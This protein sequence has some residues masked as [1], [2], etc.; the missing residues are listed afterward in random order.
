MKWL[1][2]IFLFI[3]TIQAD[4]VIKPYDFIEASGNVIDI[5]VADDMIGVSTDRGTIESYAISTK[6]QLM[7]VQFPMIKDFMG[8][9]IY[10]KIFSTDYLKISKRYLAVVQG[11]SGSRE[12]FVIKDGVKTK[13]ISEKKKLFISKAKFVDENHIMIALLSNEY[14][15]FDINKKRVLYRKHISYSHFSDFMLS[16][17]KSI[18]VGSSESGKVTVISV[19]NGNIIKTLKGGNVDN[20]YKVDIK[21]SKVLAAGQDRRGIVYDIDTGSFVRFDAHFLIYAGALSSDAL[22]AAFA[23]TEDNDIVIFDLISHKRAYTLKGQKS[24]LNSVVF[25]D[26]NTLVSGSDDRF[27][28]MWKLK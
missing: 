3:S 18:L 24:T 4:T 2:S 7:K 6:E 19:E 22:M 11:V 27:I 26:K 9:D 10:P 17:D 25:V 21:N 13:L 8:D 1:I 15:L 20:V 5:V 23:F 14:I 12:L 16:L 28:M